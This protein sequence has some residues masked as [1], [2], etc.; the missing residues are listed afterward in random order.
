M[1]AVLGY[2]LAGLGL[3]ALA[4]NSAVGRENLKFLE[5]ISS[6]YILIPAAILI[7]LGVIIM[8]M[9]SKGGR[10]KIR[11]VENEVPIYKGE[12]KKRKIVGYKVE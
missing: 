4:A 7:V 10:G 11:H 9:N 12:G 6:Q 1:K 5:N 2:I 8:I 3:L